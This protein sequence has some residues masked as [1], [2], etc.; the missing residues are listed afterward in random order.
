MTKTMLLTATALAALASPAA[1]QTATQSN[2]VEAGAVDTPAPLGEE[3]YQSANDIVVTAT[4]R[5]ETVQ[6]VPVAITA[7]GAEL[8]DDAGVTDVRG[9]EQLAPSVQTTTGQSSANNTNIAI[10]GIGTSGD[11]P[12]FEP[13]VGI[14][15]DGVFRSRAGVAV[16]ELPEL[17]RVEIL[18]GPQGTLFGRNTSAGAISIFTAQPQFDFGGYVE[19][20][21]GNYDA[22]S[23]K[24]ALTGPVTEQIALRVD[25]G[26]RKRDGYIQDANSDRAINDL[27]RYY[28]RGQALLDTGDVTFRLI[29]DYTRTDEQC[30]GALPIVRGST[31]N[32]INAIAAAQ[33]LVGIYTGPASDRIQ[34]ISPNRNYA[35]KIRDWGVS[36]ELNANIGDLKLTSI[37]AYRDW[38]VLRDQDIDF[39]GI[40]RAYRDNYTTGLID[41]TQE[42]RLQGTV[43]R[44]DF[45]IG[46]F[47]L[48]EVNR[49]TDTVR[50]G[51]DANRYVDTLLGG[52]LAAPPAAGGIGR[53]AQFFGS[54]AIPTFPQ[55][56]AALQGGPALPAGTVPLFSQLLY[57]Q[58][59]QLQ[60]AAPPGSPLFTYFNT[61]LVGNAAGQGNTDNF[62]VKTDAFA[63]FTH[64]IIRVTDE[65]SITLGARFNHES[66]K[67]N[68]SINNN[69]AA[70]GFFFS[71]DPRA[72]TLRSAIR[73]A[74]ATLFQ[75]LFLLSC[76]PAV[77]TEFNGNYDHDRSENRLT[78]T[79]K[80][81]Y[82]LSPDVLAYV[83]YDRGYK[84]GGY[85]LDQ[86]TFDS[87]V[88]GGNGAQ[89]SDLEF[90]AETVDAFELGVKMTPTRAF[91]FNAAV[92]Y[93]KFKD[94]Q[95]LA[96]AG[97]NFVVQNV[98]RTTSKGVEAEAIIQPI[99]DFTVRAGYTWL[100]ARYDSS[101]VFPAGSPLAGSAGQRITNQ[102]EHAVTLSSTWTPRLTD[103]W[104][105]L[106]H[107]D[108]RYNSEVNLPSGGLNPL[109]GRTAL[110]NPGYPLIAARVGIQSEDRTKSLE[111]WVEN[112]TNQYFNITAFPVPEQTGT[113]AGYPSQPRFYGV[114]GRFGF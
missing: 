89:G 10:R 38:S 53:Q 108:M 71:A 9:L 19:G 16:S 110:F 103:G 104:R 12:G 94:L 34:A 62:R 85:N 15:I 41:F 64:N 114:T 101:N 26:Y 32:A 84:S 22:Y 30:C 106:V 37:T 100:D 57:A 23:L 46:G 73:S 24:G 27:D 76:N 68:A 48:N 107:A 78:G 50:L 8:L 36:G 2:P 87:T 112:L 13:A 56:V 97:N 29:G 83:S 33:G 14:F 11:N 70:C 80:L 66:K 96:F 21:Y 95:N 74:S 55:L 67:L 65:L 18:R 99:R 40:D 88:F 35:E 63:L 4:R 59:P 105:G 20:S 3:D 61:A 31:A 49:L 98:P 43:G 51:N 6:E 81:S 79:A 69:T 58:S 25:A 1:A 93:Q 45:L 5:N 52:A 86:A 39:S 75:N 77:S 113:F 72:V 111:F 54:F 44:L 28:V 42:L 47:Y 82:K 92:F 7:V 90:G 91:T 17:Q 102:P 109:T 60:A